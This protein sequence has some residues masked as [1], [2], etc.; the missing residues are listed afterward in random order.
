MTITLDLG[1]GLDAAYDHEAEI[2]HGT[3]VTVQCACGWNREYAPPGVASA[4]PDDQA[5]LA[6]W[7][8]HVYAEVAPT[9]PCTPSLTGAQWVELLDVLDLA[10]G[11]GITRAD[12]LLHT[13]RSTAGID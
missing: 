10:V 8:E 11:A 6:E 7:R 3:V 1:Q 5:V 12:A 9:L 2:D 4:E 13:V